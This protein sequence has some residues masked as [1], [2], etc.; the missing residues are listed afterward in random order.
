MKKFRFF[1]LTMVVLLAMC[2]SFTACDS[3]TSTPTYTVYINSFKFSASDSDFGDLSNTYW[4]VKEITNSKFTWERDNNFI[5]H[6]G[7]QKNLTEDQI[8]SQLK[9]WNFSDS[10]AREAASKLISY[11]HSFLG[12]RD[13]TS[14]RC[15]LK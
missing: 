9:N 11:D 3:G 13:G 5:G 12:F 10:K 7:S 6:G 15:I 8:I 1:F 14:L 2:L 4:K